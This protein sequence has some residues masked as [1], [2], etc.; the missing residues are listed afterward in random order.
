[1]SRLPII[2]TVL[3]SAAIALMIGLG[4]WQLQR[5]EWKNALLAHYAEAE[6]AGPVPFPT[7]PEEVE[8]VLYRPSTVNCARVVQ[9]DAMAGR[10]A[11][12]K[13][14]WAEVARCELT[15]GGQADIVLGWIDR[16]EIA[17]WSGGD[18]SGIIGPGRDGEA[19]LVAAP[20]QAGLTAN[21]RPDPADLP[22]NHLSYAVQWFF[23][24]LTALVI[25]ILALRRRD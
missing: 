16:P 10:N 13:S 25:Y 4:I 17:E 5:A 2:P 24:A 11:S 9:L 6:N 15:A 20:P 21:A 19:R 18:V 12:G 8:Q 22:N 1:M 14:G 3:V 23:F 7:D